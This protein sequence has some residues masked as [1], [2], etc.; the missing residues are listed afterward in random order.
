MERKIPALFFDGECPMCI[1]FKQTL[2][3]AEGFEKL[4]YFDINSP[5]TYELFKELDPEAC[6]DEVHIIC[7]ED[8]VHRGPEA[9]EWLLKLNP[10][11][12]QWSWLLD[13]KMGQKAVD[14]FYKTTN[15][16]RK[17]LIKRCL[18]CNSRNNNSL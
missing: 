13:S 15:K 17:D 6:L 4:S 9:I 14:Y 2:E 18:G 11:V 12:S 8:K 1:R 16:L 3:R 7:E 10:K 5:L